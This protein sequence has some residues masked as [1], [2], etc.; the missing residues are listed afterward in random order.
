MDEAAVYQLGVGGASR[1]GPKNLA[2][3]LRTWRV[4]GFPARVR[5]TA[6]KYLLPVALSFL[7][8]GAA[9]ARAADPY[10]SDGRTGS[11]RYPTTTDRGRVVVHDHDECEDS[12][13]FDCQ[14][15]YLGIGPMWALTNFH[16]SST[17]FTGGSGANVDAGNTYGADARIGYR[18]HPNIAVE[19]QGQYYGRANFDATPAG[20]A[21]STDVGSF[22]GAS[23]TANVKIYPI[24]G[25]VQPYVLG[26]LGFLWAKV[27]N[28]IPGAKSGDDTEVAGRG[29]LGVD[30]YLDENF[31]VNIEGSYLQ[32]ASNLKDFPLAAVTGGIQYHFE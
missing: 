13:H 18:V 6:M 8:L 32:P 4:D 5:G 19:A 23:G 14:R 2:P 24:V 20:A 27:R 25:R 11:D 15:L 3:A 12:D 29:G 21:G 1:A 9:A 22:E 16:A 30:I 7:L 17:K 31:A 26:G 28:D 10:P